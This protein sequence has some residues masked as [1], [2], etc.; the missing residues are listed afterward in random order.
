M[1]DEQLLEDFRQRASTCYH[2]VGTCVMGTNIA[3]SVV[4][5]QLKVHG[6]DALFVVDAS[7]MPTVTSG[8]THAPTTLIAHMG[9][10]AILS[11]V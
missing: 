2:P 3:N 8:N 7:V 6:L 10:K 1:T 11:L 4:S 5:P 9:A